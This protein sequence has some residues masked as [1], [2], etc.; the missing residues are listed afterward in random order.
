MAINFLNTVNLNKNQ[1]NQ[2]AIENLGTDPATGVLGQIYYNTTDSALK[3][4]ITASTAAP[5]NAVWQE[6]G[7]T[8]GVETISIGNAN[9]NAGG[10]NTGLVRTPGTGIGDV[11][12]T[13]AIYGGAANVGMVPTG[14][15][16]DQYLDGA[17]NWIDITTGDIESVNAS[18]VDNRLGIA[19]TTPLGPDPVVGLDIVGLDALGAPAL[20]DSLVIYDLNADKN[21]KLT[22]ADIVGTSSWKLEGDGANQQ[23]IVNGDI[24]DFVGSTYI[25]SVASSVSANNFAVTLTHDNTTRTDTPSTSSPGYGGDIVAIKAITTNTTGHVTIVETE[26]YT[27]PND[28]NETYTLPVSAGAANSAV[29]DLTAGGTGSGVKSSVTFLGTTGRIAIT[30]QTGNNGSITVDFPDDVTIV[31]D[32][33]VGGIITQ[34]G[35]GSTT[36]VNNGAVSSSANLLLTANNTA[37]KVGMQVTGTGIPTNITIASVT[38][39]KT[40]VLS[41]AIT[42]ANGITITFEEVNSFAA[43]LDMNNNRL[44]EVKTG[45]LGTDG[46][47]LGQVELLVAGVGVFKGGY[48]ATS[49]PGTPKISGADNIALDQGDY[50]IVTHDGDITFSDQVVKVEVGDFIFANAP[51]LADDD[52]ASTEYTIVIADANIAGAGATDG[53]T[54]KGVAGFDSANFTVSASGWVQIKS[55]SRLNGRKQALDDGGSATPATS[56][57]ERTVSGGLTTFEIDL[58]D[59]SLFGSGALAEDVTVEVTQNVSPYQTVY[60][61]VTRSGSASMSIIFSGDVAVDTYRVLLEYI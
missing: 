46:V 41:G 61:D 58:A 5:S 20:T 18:D 16:V 7:A 2:A 27:L 37:I 12:I 15:T 24:V 43:P 56:P 60:A 9:V 17:G 31:D 4:C 45:V 8:S 49:D 19:I 36:G 57:V 6:V 1:L 21:K 55:L 25:S 3:I 40:F 28:T 26:T 54:E 39:A 10:V 30:E 34:S 29:I 53:A 33:T 42:I 48:N 52:P 50:F 13:P 22:I 14:G 38:D 11:V 44:H 59:A 35:L 32:L 47:N 51:I 23:T